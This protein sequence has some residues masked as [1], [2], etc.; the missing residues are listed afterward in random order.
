MGAAFEKLVRKKVLK[1]TKSRLAPGNTAI[2]QKVN[3]FCR[4]G[5]SAE[6]VIKHHY[7]QTRQQSV[8]KK[9]REHTTE[10]NS[11]KLASLDF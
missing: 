9:S 5:T 7:F 8:E 1:W 11:L 6:V 4:G 3:D 2:G 10:K